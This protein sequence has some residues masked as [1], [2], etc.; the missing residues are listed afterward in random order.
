MAAKVKLVSA[1]TLGGLEE[2]VNEVVEEATS[3]STSVFRD[4][5]FYVAVVSY[6]EADG[7]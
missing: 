6:T 4:N 5:S 3:A 7:E 1:D 2:A